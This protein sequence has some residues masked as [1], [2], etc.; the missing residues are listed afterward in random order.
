MPRRSSGRSYLA[1]P[2]LHALD[3]SARRDDDDEEEDD[4]DDEEVTLLLTCV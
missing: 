2:A 4:D 3:L 1:S